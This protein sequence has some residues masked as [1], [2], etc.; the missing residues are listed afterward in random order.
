MKNIWILSFIV[1]LL[2]A[3]GNTNSPSIDKANMLYEHG[4]PEES[5]NELI[6]VVFSNLSQEDKAEAHYILGSIAFD[7]K[8]IGVALKYWKILVSDF[9]KSEKAIL[10][11][12]K[13]S[14]LAEI[15]GE[16]TEESIKNAVAQSYLRHGD[17]WSEGKDR[18]FQIDS[19]WIQNVESAIK[20]YDKVITEFPKSPAAARA[21]KG[22]LRALL[23]WEESGRYGSS[24]GVKMDFNKYTPQL[25]ATFSA[26]EQEFPK[27]GVLQAFRYQIGQAYWN[28]KDWENTKIWLNKIIDITGNQ[29]SFYKD[30]AQRRMLKVEH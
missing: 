20:W 24:H 8:R 4:L 11:K 7:E 23:G 12:D 6:N 9:P 15:V 13:I 5:K 3:C 16:S 25:L 1:I 27:A 19:S 17:F 21:Y 30:L 28:N 22:K 18:V 10:V 14:E 26:F 29:D 2:S